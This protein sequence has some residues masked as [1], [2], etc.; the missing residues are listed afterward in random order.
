MDG[1]TIHRLAFE[2]QQKLK[3]QRFLHVL[4]V[5]HA[6]VALATLHDVDPMH[7][8]V[9][10]LLH[11]SSKEMRPDAIKADLEAKGLSIPEEDIP[12]PA[13]WHGL[14]AAAR[15]RE[16]ASLPLGEAREEIAHAVEL[17]STAEEN[18]SALTK[19][20][21]LADALEPG[22]DYEGVDELRALARRDLNE[23]FRSTLEHK[24]RF[25]ESKGLPVSPRARR[26]LDYFTRKESL[27]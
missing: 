23:A 6:A 22:R 8:A 25:V 20:L 4:G 26:A 24:C 11:D 2:A 14:H 16:D 12:F 19:V 1:S 17:H 5:T 3:P 13:L 10:A 18:A 7:A 21:F 9:A 27:I 15:A